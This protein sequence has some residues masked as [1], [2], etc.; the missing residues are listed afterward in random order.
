MSE[1]H[2]L[3]QKI[4]E[5]SFCVNDLTLFLDNHPTDKG[6][7]DLFDKYSKERKELLNEYEACFEP[8]TVDMVQTDSVHEDNP[9]CHHPDKRHFTWTDGPT[10]WEGG[11]I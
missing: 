11:H 9:F 3:L 5:V 8:L 4:S 10:P 2:N 1:R 7:L 6:A